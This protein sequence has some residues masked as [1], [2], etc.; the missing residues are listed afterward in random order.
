MGGREGEGCLR[1][2]PVC[3]CGRR[4]VPATA[5]IRLLTLPT[6]VLPLARARSHSLARTRANTSLTHARPETDRLDLPVQWLWDMVD[7]FVY[8]FTD[9]CRFRTKDLKKRS[10]ADVELMAQKPKIWDT[11]QASILARCGW[12]PVFSQA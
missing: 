9:F 8:Q 11:M 7:E 6:H 3:A 10:P 2:W 5:S 12:P 4:G 1:V